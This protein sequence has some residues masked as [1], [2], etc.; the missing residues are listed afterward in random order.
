MFKSS[1][2]LGYVANSDFYA[3]V[4]NCVNNGKITATGCIGDNGRFVSYVSGIINYGL[5]ENADHTIIVTS[6]INNGDLYSVEEL[7]TTAPGNPQNQHAYGYVAVSSYT[8]LSKAD[9]VNYSF[10][11]NTNTGK[12]YYLNEEA[13]DA[14]IVIADAVFGPYEAADEYNNTTNIAE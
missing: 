6:N 3:E 8:V 10:M 9:V 2:I 5:S 14:C 1:G 7:S 12:V 13:T 11:N 4:K